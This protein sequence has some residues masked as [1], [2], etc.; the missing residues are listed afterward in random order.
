[1]TFSKDSTTIGFIFDKH[2][3]VISHLD[4]GENAVS[5]TS[6]PERLL[7]LALSFIGALVVGGLA[8]T[9]YLHVAGNYHITAVDAETRQPI[10]GCSLTVGD[11]NIGSRAGGKA[12]DGWAD[13]GHH[14][15]LLECP[16]YFPA[17]AE[18]QVSQFGVAYINCPDRTCAGRIP[19]YRAS[20]LMD[21]LPTPC[22]CQP[23]L[24]IPAPPMP[25]DAPDDPVI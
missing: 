4:N 1:L 14:T 21:P 18:L 7:V 25:P 2:L 19:A 23:P 11:A 5:T 6:V 20:W 16:G 12:F 9:F 17:E 24:A 15:L 13:R 8:L 22:D 10:A 3:L